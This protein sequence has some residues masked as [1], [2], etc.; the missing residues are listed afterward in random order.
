MLY[1]IVRAVVGIALRLFYRIARVTLDLEQWEDLPLARTAEQLYSLRAGARQRDPERLRRFARGIALLRA[2]QPERFDELRRAVAS[3]QT[4]LDLVDATPADLRI[5][6]GP[7]SVARFVLRNLVALIA[8]LPLFWVGLVV[9]APPFLLTRF[10]TRALRPALDRVA[11]YKLV[12]TLFVAPLWWALATVV[13]HRMGGWQAAVATF[14]AALPLA[15]FTRRFFERRRAAIADALTFLAIGT[16]RSLR[17]A[18]VR[19]GEALSAEIERVATE[20]R[21]RVA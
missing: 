16:R 13:A 20:L 14:A 19:E 9:F 21:E 17:A 4:R 12:G 18:L 1:G 11:T 15:L 8:G 3:Y 6:Y 7:T 2:E 10:V 5:H